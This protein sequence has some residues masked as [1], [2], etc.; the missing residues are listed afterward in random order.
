[1]PGFAGVRD[2]GGADAL[3]AAGDEKTLG[4]H[5]PLIIYRPC[6]GWLAPPRRPPKA[7]FVPGLETVAVDQLVVVFRAVALV[8]AVVG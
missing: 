4:G 2:D 7:V 1:M 6:P 3:A 5:G 8:V